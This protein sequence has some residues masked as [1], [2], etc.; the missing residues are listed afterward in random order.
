M[1]IQ[2]SEKLQNQA[3]TYTRSTSVLGNFEYKHTK[4]TNS[5]NN[6]YANKKH[7]LYTINKR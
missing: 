2:K 6:L 5:K 4:K 1:K 7:P 3:I